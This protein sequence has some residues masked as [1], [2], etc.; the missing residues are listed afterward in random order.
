MVEKVEGVFKCQSCGGEAELFLEEASVEG[1]SVGT[2]V[3]KACGAREEVSLSDV[4]DEKLKAV[5]IAV[6]AEREAFLFY[7]EAAEKSS[8]PR[9]KDMFKQLSDF[10]IG[11]Y[12]ALIHLFLSLK[13]EK[14]WIPYKGLGELKTSNRIE[15]SREGY[16][17]KEDDVQALRIAIE[18]EA[19]AADFYRKMAEE[20]ED[21][22]G[23]EMFTRL[24]KE[25]EMH[26]QLL[27]DQYYALLN[28]GEWVW[29]D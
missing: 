12:K 4:Q 6:D 26:R 23:K 2:L 9:G 25:E 19:K 16:T 7:R 17:S 27:N 18:K 24:A 14:R 13:Q 28:Q 3:C 20:T 15:A 11:H 29:G 8:S 5:K 22:E 1:G 21:P 10:E